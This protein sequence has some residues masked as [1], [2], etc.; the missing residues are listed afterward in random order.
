MEIKKL[1]IATVLIISGCQK[2]VKTAD[3]ISNLT[4]NPTSINADGTS[5][6]AISVRL[7]DN[8]AVDKRNIIFTATS[9]T[10]IGAK[11]DTLNV[12][13][14][15][16][17]KKIVA[18]A[19][20]TS[21]ASPG[22]ITVTAS[23]QALTKSG[24]FMLS[25][26]IQANKVDPAAIKLEP[27]S[28]GI[29]SNAISEVTLTGTITGQSGGNASQGVKVILEDFLTS[30]RPAGGHFRAAQLT[31]NSSSQISAVYAAGNLPLGSNINIIA[32]ILD[33]QGNKTGMIS[34]STLTI[35]K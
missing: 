10:W 4:I 3:I 24:N 27:S 17:D 32:T 34:T 2:E 26:T 29:G 22:V 7:N 31:S 12:P 25:G 28:L 23:S 19:I 9:G 35:N 6:V 11:G 30:S 8:A 1:L 13:A 18:K 21:P 20:L 14:T 5:S 16:S 33:D 15:Y